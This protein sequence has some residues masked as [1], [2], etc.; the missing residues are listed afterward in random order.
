V[1]RYRECRKREDMQE[2]IGE[3]VAKDRD[4]KKPGEK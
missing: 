3:H 4:L 2:L 1:S